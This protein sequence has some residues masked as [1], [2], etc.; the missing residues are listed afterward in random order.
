MIYKNIQQQKK[1]RIEEFRQKKERPL[2]CQSQNP[3]TEII[4][5]IYRVLNPNPTYTH[6]HTHNASS[7]TFSFTI[8]MWF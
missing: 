4:L 7:N 1:R 8:R 5:C 6:K 2:L 3:D